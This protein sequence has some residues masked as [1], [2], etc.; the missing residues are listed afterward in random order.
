MKK[1]WL[2]LILALALCL[3]LASPAMAAEA[4]AQPKAYTC[5]KLLWIG[6]IPVAGLTVINNEY[7]VPIATLRSTSKQCVLPISFNYTGDDS[8]CFVLADKKFEKMGQD[9]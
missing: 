8:I 9:K 2:S 6:P 7:Y 4:P 3:G 5:D 1:K